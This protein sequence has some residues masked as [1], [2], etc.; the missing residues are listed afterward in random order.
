MRHSYA[1]LICARNEEQVI[2]ALIE[3]LR[4]QTYAADKLHIFVL[5]DNC[6]DNTAAVARSAGAAVYER[7]NRRQIGKGYAPEALLRHLSVAR[8]GKRLIPPTGV[9]L[10]NTKAVR[11]LDQH[12]QHPAR[13]YRKADATNAPDR[14]EEI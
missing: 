12:Q 11:A 10:D 4:R 8:T 7:R 13:D 6:T 9:T 14:Y 5:A 3:S 2:A 1:A